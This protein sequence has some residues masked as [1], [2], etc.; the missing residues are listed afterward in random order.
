MDFSNSFISSNYI[1]A[2]KCN[3]VYEDVKED[4]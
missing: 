2:N 3:T 4:K 1:N